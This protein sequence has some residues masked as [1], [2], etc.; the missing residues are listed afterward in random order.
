[1]FCFSLVLD[2]LGHTS[3]HIGEVRLGL[4][5]FS[6][7]LKH[8]QK[9]GNGGVSTAIKIS[10]LVLSSHVGLL[11]L[12]AIPE[13][14]RALE[15]LR[16]EDNYSRAELLLELSRQYMLSG[17]ADDAKIMLDRSCELI[18]SSR[19][20]R[21]A[22]TLNLRYAYYYLRRG[23]PRTALNL[24]R[25]A[26]LSLVA[27]TDRLLLARLRGLESQ[28]LLRIS[29]EL[30]NQAATIFVTDY[31]HRR[32]LARQT[33]GLSENLRRGEDPMGDLVDGSAARDLTV[34]SELVRLGLFGLLSSFTQ[35]VDHDEVLALDLLSDS[36][37]SMTII[38]RGNVMHNAFAKNGIAR[39]ILMPLSEGWVGKEELVQRVWGYRYS[40]MRHDTLV[41]AAVK[42]LRKQMGQYAHWIESDEGAYRLRK[43]VV[44]DSLS[45]EKVKVIAPLVRDGSE[46]TWESVP[47]LSY[48]QGEILRHLKSRPGKA[49]G[50]RECAQVFSTSKITASR[51]LTFLYE[52][53]MVRRLGKG[54]ATCY[55]RA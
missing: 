49:V 26:E 5:N 19:N 13:L 34:A 23:E 25:T 9:I 18:Y 15:V 16:P 21:Q 33:G 54:R 32:I 2:L 48:R 10:K 51:D 12:K 1:M 7:A 17:K 31:T 22:A 52:M 27:R 20:R 29:P 50:V 28:I 42:T 3:A 44:L 41:Y 14:K 24:V 35:K 8:A 43:S 46:S 11:G 6:E 4:K 53:K 37:G 36:H 40:P 38:E 39:K 30:K 45:T 47:G 55:V